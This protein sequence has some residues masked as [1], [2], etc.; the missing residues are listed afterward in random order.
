M[1]TPEYIVTG[2]GLFL[3]GWYLV[4]AIYNRR[5]GLRTYRWLQRGLAELGDPK[6]VQASWIGSS[7]SG[8]RIGMQRAKAPFRR[9]ELV[10]LLESRELAP[11]WL[12][13]MLRGKRDQLIL[14][15]TLRTKPTG[16]LEVLPD[17][18]RTR[19]DLQQKTTVS[20]TV[21]D[22]PHNLLIACRGSTEQQTQWLTPFL[23]QYGPHLKHLSWGPQDPHLLI[24]LRLAGLPKQ[25]AVILFRDIRQVAGWQPDSSEAEDR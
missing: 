21:K 16:E 17:K 18:I 6:S 9:L 24:I 22:G 12:V 4:A 13:D 3:V 5:F 25:E 8:A 2:L 15:G 7:G 11:L 23:E 20:W 14:R 10:Y 1:L 19:K